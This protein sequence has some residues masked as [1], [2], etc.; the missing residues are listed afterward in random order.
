LL[1]NQICSF[2]HEEYTFFYIPKR[3]EH[4]LKAHN[5]NFLVIAS[6]TGLKPK[7]MVTNQMEGL[8]EEVVLPKLIPMTV[9]HARAL[10][11]ECI[12]CKLDMQVM[13]YHENDNVISYLGSFVH[14]HSIEIV[15]IKTTKTFDIPKK[16]DIMNYLKIEEYK[17]IELEYKFDILSSFVGSHQCSWIN[18]SYKTNAYKEFDE[19]VFDY[20][21]VT[22]D[23]YY[24]CSEKDPDNHESTFFIKTQLDHLS[25]LISRNEDEDEESDDALDLKVDTFMDDLK[26]NGY[27]PKPK[28]SIFKPLPTRMNLDFT[29]HVWG[30]FQ[31]TSDYESSFLKIISEI[32]QGFIPLV[33]MY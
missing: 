19:K 9:E 30:F 23:A 28:E 6:R 31:T 12:L 25:A 5:R 13:I 21:N 33:Y 7:L 24:V 4:T 26:S 22:L 17:N 20:K 3:F 18:L 27:I 8:K 29:D 1:S 32:E 16:D 10:N 14:E 15:T 2:D 11:S